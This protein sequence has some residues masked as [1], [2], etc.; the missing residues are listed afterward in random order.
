MPIEL[1]PGTASYSDRSPPPRNRQ[2]LLFGAMAIALV[3]GFFWALDLLV[4]GVVWL[5]PP[6]VERQLGALTVPAFERM[7]KPSPTQDTLNQLLD[8]LEAHLPA[9]QRQGR[10]YQVLYLPEQTINAAAIPGDRIILYDG[11]LQQTDSENELMMVLGHELG[12]FAHRDHL[13]AL[14]RGLV[15]QVFLAGLIGDVGSLQSIALSGVATLSNARFSQTQEYE[16]DDFGL[17]LL[18]ATYGQVAGATDFFE[19][20]SRLDLP[21]VAFLTSHP[22]SRKRVQRLEQAIQE[23]GYRIGERSPLPPSLKIAS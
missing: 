13:R 5:I 16:A 2:L 23:R 11:L 4:T 6:A 17:D 18:H 10:D 3:I 12:H 1:P 22:T 14:G 9:E 19:R 15:V 21:N 7:A 8:R 20:M